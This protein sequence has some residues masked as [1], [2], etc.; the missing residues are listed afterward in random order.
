MTQA[1]Q[2]STLTKH[3]RHKSE[4]KR[5]YQ[6]FPAKPMTKINTLLRQANTSTTHPTKT[7]NSKR[8]KLLE[9]NKEN[10]NMSNTGA[11]RSNHKMAATSQPPRGAAKT[12]AHKSHSRRQREGM[13][14]SSF[15]SNS[16]RGNGGNSH[17]GSSRH[18]SKG[19]HPGSSIAEQ[20]SKSYFLNSKQLLRHLSPA[21][22][23]Q[24]AGVS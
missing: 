16:N 14:I 12:V 21:R 9:Q 10:L 22:P 3:R 24:P 7:S 8:G 15:S 19:R 20:L 6:Q 11:D 5:G 23:E 17:A 1:K 13:S 18:N 4:V 2:A